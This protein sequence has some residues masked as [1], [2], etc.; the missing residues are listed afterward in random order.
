MAH[1]HRNRYPLARVTAVY[2]AYPAGVGI[3]EFAAFTGLHPDLVRRYVTLGLLEPDTDSAGGL[4][5]GT[6]H[7]TRVARIQRLRAGLGLNY[8]ALA[9]VLDL[10]DRV[11]QL[12]AAL[13]GRHPDID[14]THGG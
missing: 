13:A 8:A 12:E 10:L 5:F 6:A 2:G 4:W 3:D 9:V 1:H 11:E 14:A 7:L